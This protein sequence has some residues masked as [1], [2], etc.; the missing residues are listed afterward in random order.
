MIVT[1]HPIFEIMVRERAIFF[2]NS[3]AFNWNITANDV[4]WLQRAEK[5]LIK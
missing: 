4:K 3:D 2:G 1:K 5:Y